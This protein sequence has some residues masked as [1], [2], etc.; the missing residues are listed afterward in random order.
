MVTYEEVEIA[1]TN[2]QKWLKVNTQK[3]ML[4]MIT[5]KITDLVCLISKI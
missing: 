5:D 1:T 2:I 3:K 4:K